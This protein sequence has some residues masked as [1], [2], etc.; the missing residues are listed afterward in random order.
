LKTDLALI[1]ELMG[2]IMNAIHSHFGK[3]VNYSQEIMATP[4]EAHFIEAIQDHPK[5]NT[6]EIAEILGLTKANISLRAARLCKKGYIEKYNRPSN[7]KEIYYRL[8]TFGHALYDAHAAY[9]FNRNRSV[10]KRFN[11]YP[12]EEKELIIG[13]LL[14]Y[15]KYMGDFYNLDVPKQGG[16]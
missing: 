10:Y 14:E 8:T 16:E 15:A 3:L 7:R 6:N 13:F 11:A 12:D 9:H 2:R 4:A 1:D 5:S